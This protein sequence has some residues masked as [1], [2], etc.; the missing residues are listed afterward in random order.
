MSTIGEFVN[1][2]PGSDLDFDKKLR[3]KVLNEC[4]LGLV[5]YARHLA[6]DICE[7]PER[8]A[9]QASVEALPA[10][11]ASAFQRAIKVISDCEEGVFDS[12]LAREL[13]TCFPSQFHN[14]LPRIAR[15]EDA[16]LGGFRNVLLG[17]GDLP[18][19]L[20]DRDFQDGCGCQQPADDA[21]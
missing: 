14:R 7:W 1:D 2:F 9:L 11:I 17:G 21:T 5:T 18:R 20:T 4:W 12:A 10:K 6:L 16:A 3:E 8:T 13:L 15:V 19:R